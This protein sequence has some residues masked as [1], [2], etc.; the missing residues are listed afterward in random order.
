MSKDKAK[1]LT[2]EAL[3][4]Q[5]LAATSRGRAEKLLVSGQK[6]LRR[7]KDEHHSEEQLVGRYV[8]ERR[9]AK[10][11]STSQPLRLQPRN[12]PSFSC[13]NFPTCCARM[14]ARARVHVRAATAGGGGWFVRQHDT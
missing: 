4:A 2:Q 1:R 10:R 14:C 13:S 11:Y 5:H 3:D 9:Q 7:A 6:S 8:Q 12:W